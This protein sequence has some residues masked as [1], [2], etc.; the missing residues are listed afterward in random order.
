MARRVV[1]L[2]R[3]PAGAA[4]ANDAAL[5]ANAFAVAEDLDLTLV[6]R[7]RGVELAQHRPPDAPLELA[8][9]PL[10]DPAAASDLQGLL[11]SG[12]PVFVGADCLAELGLGPDD[13]LAGVRIVDAPAIA[14][15]LRDADAVVAW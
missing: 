12:V 7:G 10:P 11:E 9:R 15:L 8:G 2:L 14:G 6:L 4:R 13:L 5:E 3:G 1:S